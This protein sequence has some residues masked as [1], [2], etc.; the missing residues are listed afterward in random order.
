MD[1]FLL[2]S[3]LGIII[4]KLTRKLGKE[5]NPMTKEEILRRSRN[6]RNDEGN[7]YAAQK[8]LKYGYISFGLISMI[9]IIADAFGGSDMRAFY[10][11]SALIWGFFSTIN[12]ESARFK[13]N[14]TLILASI[15]GALTA[16]LSLIRYFYILLG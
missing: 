9:I 12:F 6:E 11:V 10:A 15:L 13:H 4:I 3:I 14:K 7:E 1:V 2:T 16:I 8:G 5:V